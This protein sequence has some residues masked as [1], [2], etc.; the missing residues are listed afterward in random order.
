MVGVAEARAE[1]E[2]FVH[3]TP[4]WLLDTHS[5]ST[6]I[7][8]VTGKELWQSPSTAVT[9]SGEGVGWR[10]GGGRRSGVGGGVTGQNK[11]SNQSR[12]SVRRGG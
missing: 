5:G 10:F 2:S 12:S 7:H 6:T 4:V 11:L 8:F 9:F 3:F 1:F